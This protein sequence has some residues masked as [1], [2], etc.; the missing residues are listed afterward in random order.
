[1]RVSTQIPPLSSVSGMD[2]QGSSSVVRFCK[3]PSSQTIR[4]KELIT[5]LPEMNDLVAY[6]FIDYDSSD[7][8]TP[9]DACVKG[10][11]MLPKWN[12]SVGRVTRTLSSGGSISIGGNDDVKQQHNR[13]STYNIKNSLPGS[14]CVPTAS[15]TG[16]QSIIEIM[17]LFRTEARYC[18]M[19][20][21]LKNT[22]HNWSD[23]GQGSVVFMKSDKVHGD[24][25]PSSIPPVE[26]NLATDAVEDAETHHRQ[27]LECNST[28]NTTTPMKDLLG[29]EDNV[30]KVC[31]EHIDCAHFSVPI[32]SSPQLILSSAVFTIFDRNALQDAGLVDVHTTT[33]SMPKGVESVYIPKV[34]IEEILTNASA[35]WEM[36]NEGERDVNYS[37][38]FGQQPSY[39]SFLHDVSD[40]GVYVLNNNNHK[41][42][43]LAA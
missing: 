5:V 11:V 35:R 27:P 12:W 7:M 24:I 31:L 1:M 43:T 29:E 25:V 22:P 30:D 18:N 3:E 36:S 16:P 15:E 23:K 13:F 14:E 41:S 34:L 2:V 21:I 4:S 17:P 6:E 8:S 32:S 33:Q 38:E 9:G 37:A 28:S 19:P 20:I 40:N 26:W 42:H 39:S 10:E